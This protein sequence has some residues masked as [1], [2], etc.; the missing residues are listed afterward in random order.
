MF[1]VQKG[2]PTTH[3]LA[4]SKVIF[5]SLKSNESLLRYFYTVHVI[6]NTQKKCFSGDLTDVNAKKISLLPLDILSTNVYFM[7]CTDLGVAVR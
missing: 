3:P 6:F 1:R 2:L 4:S 7:Y 5:F